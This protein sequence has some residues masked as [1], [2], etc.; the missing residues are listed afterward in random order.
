MAVRGVYSDEEK[1]NIETFEKRAEERVGWQKPGGGPFGGGM[2]ES[3][4][5]SVDQ[6]KKYGYETDK[7]NPFWY[8]EGYA[9]V[10]RWGSLIAHPWFGS[11][12]KPEEIM[13]PTKIGLFRTFYL[14]GHDIECY[15]PIRAGDMIRTW[16]KKPTIEDS[17]A[18]NGKGPRKFRYVDGWGDMINQRNEIVYT[19]KQFVEVTL[20]DNPIIYE[21]WM[22][23]Y[24]YSAKELAFMAKT[25]DAENPRGGN[26][27]YWED[28]KVGDKLDL[29][30]WGPTEFIGM[31]FDQPPKPNEVPKRKLA[32]Y[33]EPLGGPIGYP[34]V[35]DK[36]TGLVYPTHGGR[37][38]WDRAAQ[39]EGGSRAWIFNFESR[40]PMTRCVTNWMGDDAFLC[41]FSWRH[42]WRTP[43]G[44]TLLVNG[45]VVK[46]YEENG[47]HL[48]DLRVWCLNL[49]GSITDMATATVKLVSRTED[50]PGAVK[51]I[52][53]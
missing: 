47:E 29:I 31:N 13:F 17:T 44:D 35:P 15:Q 21:K 53:R 14:M 11:Q 40:L 26:V 8:M 25:I 39:Y 50:F 38:V 23:D 4:V 43:V 24:G 20:W 32:P 45:K 22:D 3:R 10:S 49:R 1:K 36:K 37:H 12:Y 18:L 41:K 6:I 19:E 2:G 48:V 9:Q 30:C 28:T 27:R 33:E 34:Y 5:I 52:N 16:A 42:V 51:V 46:K 7:W